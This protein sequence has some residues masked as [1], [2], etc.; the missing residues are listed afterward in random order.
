MLR[1]G[2]DTGSA[3][4]HLMSRARVTI[5]AVGDGATVLMWTDR[6]A[7]TVVAVKETPALVKVTVQEDRAVRTDSNG[8]SE[9]QAYAFTPNPA[10]PLQTFT[11]RK[12][13][14][15]LVLRG[16]GRGLLLGHREEYRDFSF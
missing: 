5:P 6:H 11:F 15:G 9:V 7:A 13:P 1:L 10:A 4:N 2:L 14:G 3:I 16:K 12:T 8:M